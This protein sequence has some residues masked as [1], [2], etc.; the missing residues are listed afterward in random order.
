M[1]FIGETGW[2]LSTFVLGPAA[3]LEKGLRFLPRLGG[4]CNG[5]GF[6]LLKL[7]LIDILGPLF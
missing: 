6:S 2:D 5:R 1:V 3:K 4:A 7:D